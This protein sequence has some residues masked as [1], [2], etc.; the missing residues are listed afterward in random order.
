VSA[1]YLAAAAVHVAM[2]QAAAEQ[3]ARHANHPA[4]LAAW[5]AETQRAAAAGD[6]DRVAALRPAAARV[7]TDAANELIRSRAPRPYTAEDARRLH[8]GLLVALVGSTILWTIGYWAGTRL[9][10][11]MFW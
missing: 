4:D 8:R 7:A 6:A 2:E 9:G 3:R 10:E 5:V 11:A 1:A